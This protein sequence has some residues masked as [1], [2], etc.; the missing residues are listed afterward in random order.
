MQ[1][2]QKEF[3]PKAGLLR[4]AAQFRHDYTDAVW[5]AISYPRMREKHLNYWRRA[6]S[7]MS[8]PFRSA[9]KKWRAYGTSCLRYW[10]SYLRRSGRRRCFYWPGD[11]RAYPRTFFRLKGHSRRNARSLRWPNPSRG[12]TNRRPNMSRRIQHGSRTF[13]CLCARSH[14]GGFLTNRTRLSLS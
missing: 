3:E 6:V 13:C 12:R 11:Y 2:L 9:I 1:R 5:L 4:L 8:S 14:H 7:H 10:S